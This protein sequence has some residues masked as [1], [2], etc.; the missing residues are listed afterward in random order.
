MED[1]KKKKEQTPLD[2]I[3]AAAKIIKSDIRELPCDKNKYPFIDKM[4]DIE[5]AKTWV[6]ESLMF[7]SHLVSSP[8]KQVSIG[9]SIAQSSRPR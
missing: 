4:E 8:L 5:Y 9:Q 7:L 6:P 3:I 2:V 1:F